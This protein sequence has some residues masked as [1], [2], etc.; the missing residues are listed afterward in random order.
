[1][2]DGQHLC[3]AGKFRTDERP[4]LGESIERGTKKRK[5][6]L[7]HVG[8]LQIDIGANEVDVATGPFFKVGGSMDNIGQFIFLCS[9]FV[10]HL[11]LRQYPL[12]REAFITG[13][14]VDSRN[15]R[16]AERCKGRALTRER[17]TQEHFKSVPQKAAR[18]AIVSGELDAS[19]DGRG[20]EARLVDGE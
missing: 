13:V 2:T 18:A 6:V 1:I 5:G 3:C 4:P 20:A 8:M 9:H 7:S 17:Q 11:T 16:K 12:S 19:G 10:W 15:K 14:V